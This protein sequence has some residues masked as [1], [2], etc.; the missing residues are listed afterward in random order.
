MNNLLLGPF[1]GELGW[2]TLYW[3]GVCNDYINRFKFDVIIVICIK[4]HE[5]FYP[6]ADK[7]FYLPD[8][9]IPPQV[10]QNSY[11]LD[12]WI[13]GYP[14]KA[15]KKINLR[16]SFRSSIRNLSL[17]KIYHEVPYTSKDGLSFEI[18][19]WLHKLISINKLNNYKHLNPLDE[20]CIH[21]IGLGTKIIN[22]KPTIFRPNIYRSYGFRPQINKELIPKYIKE[23][24]QS[25]DIAI[26]PRFRKER[27]PDKNSSEVFYVNLINNLKSKYPDRNIFLMGAPGGAYFVGKEMPGT[28][29]LINLPKE[30]E[31]SR[32][33]LHMYVL[34]NINLSLGSI[35]GAILLALSCGSNA[36]TW[37]EKEQFNRYHIENINLNKLIYI[38]KTSI[39]LTECFKNIGEILT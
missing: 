21:E 24:I 23:V 37:G 33:F 11:I 20:S 18:N 16:R 13:N 14:G 32:L 8:K 9:Y 17:R 22:N 2:E 4:G 30:L 39:S 27:R 29:D 25:K 35:S 26:F 10:S 19:D 1:I 36:I 31:S 38:P 7:F 34:N 3:S 15:S 12:N 28:I 5:G 6:Y